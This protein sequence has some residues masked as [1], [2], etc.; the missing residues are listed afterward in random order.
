MPLTA[1][2]SLMRSARNF[3]TFQL[4]SD[5]RFE[6]THDARNGDRWATVSELGG[7]F[8][9]EPGLVAERLCR[10]EPRRAC[11]HRGK[12][13]TRSVILR[14][15]FGGNPSQKMLVCRVKS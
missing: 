7:V 4:R 1:D 15:R 6:T 5:A 14:G 13:S 2:D 8:E 12:T 11:G 9:S 3:A 10:S